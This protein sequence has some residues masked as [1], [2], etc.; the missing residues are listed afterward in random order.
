[1]EPCQFADK[2]N[3]MHGDIKVLV[4]EFKAMNGSLRDTKLGYEKH[5][6]ESKDYRNK[7][8]IIWSAI[9]TAKWSILLLFGTGLIWKLL[10]MVSK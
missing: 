3:E 5:E 4:S 9:H 2:I 7:V 6:N 8:N 10:E 1:M